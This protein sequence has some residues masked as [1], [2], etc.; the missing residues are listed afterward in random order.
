MLALGGPYHLRHDV[1]SR[2]PRE[3]LHLA[4]FQALFVQEMHARRLVDADHILVLPPVWASLLVNQA[5]AVLVVVTP[6]KDRPT[7][8]IAILCNGIRTSGIRIRIHGNTDLLHTS[9]DCCTQC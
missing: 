8:G 3:I 6:L 4:D 9:L 1:V 2:G 5:C 7:E